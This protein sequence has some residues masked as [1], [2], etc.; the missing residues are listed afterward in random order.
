MDKK[1][2][3]NSKSMDTQR[4]NPLPSQPYDLYIRILNDEIFA[5]SSLR[6]TCHRQ[7]A[8]DKSFDKEYNKAL[9]NQINWYSKEIA[10]LMQKLGEV[11]DLQVD[12]ERKSDSRHHTRI[13]N[14]VALVVSIIAF[15]A[16]IYIV[17]F[18]NVP[19]EASDIGIPEALLLLIGSLGLGISALSPIIIGI[20]EAKKA[21]MIAQA[22]AASALAGSI[23]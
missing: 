18:R 10:V 9:A 6:E 20:I 19:G 14:Y 12:T 21:L 15:F 2:G 22:Q 17:L 16:G 4:V 1:I 11:N 23:N 3:T 5:L 8:S 7:I 13:R